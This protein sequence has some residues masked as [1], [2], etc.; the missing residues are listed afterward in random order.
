MLTLKELQEISSQNPYHQ[1]C[2]FHVTDCGEGS[3]EIHMDVSPSDK[4]LWNIVHGGVL[5]SLCDAASGMAIRTT[6]EGHYVTMS[7]SFHFLRAAM[8]EETLRASARIIKDGRSI[9]LV[10]VKLYEGEN[11]IADGLFEY[12]CSCNP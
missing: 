10:E 7:S 2:G 8:G 11:F 1:K 6:H 5:F 12:Y 4:N 3:C 9:A